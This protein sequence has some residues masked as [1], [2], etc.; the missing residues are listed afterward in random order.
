MFEGKSILDILQMGGFTTP[1]E[2]L[3]EA[4][5]KALYDTKFKPAKLNGMARAVCL[6]FVFNFKLE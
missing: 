1:D 5:K 2:Y 3:S 6:Q 4:S